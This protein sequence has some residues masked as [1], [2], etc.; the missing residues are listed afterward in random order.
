MRLFIPLRQTTLHIPGTGPERDPERGHL[1][2]VLTSPNV[3]KQVLATSVSSY[4]P[5]CDHTCIL[6]SGCHKF[7]KRKSFVLYAQ[8]STF[9][10]EKI[11]Q[12]VQDGEIRYMGLIEETI[13]EKICDGLLDSPH[14]SP[15]IRAFFNRN[16]TAE[17]F[18]DPG[19]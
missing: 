4:Y 14:T 9:P 2:I 8:A 6:E 7:I 3:E 1:F 16:A 12:R 17:R 10:A 19:L 11:I 5:R 15:H 18:P 13:F